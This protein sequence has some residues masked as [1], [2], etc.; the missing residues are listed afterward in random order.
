MPSFHLRPERAT[1]RSLCTQCFAYWHPGSPRFCN[2]CRKPWHRDRSR[3]RRRRGRGQLRQPRHGS[4]CDPHSIDRAP[5]H[6]ASWIFMMSAAFVMCSA[7][8]LKWSRPGHRPASSLPAPDM[9]AADC[10]SRPDSLPA[11][12]LAGTFADHA[13]CQVIPAR[14]GATAF[15]DRR[16]IP[17]PEGREF[18]EPGMKIFR[19]GR[20]SSRRGQRI[21]TTTPNSSFRLSVSFMSG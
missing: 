15:R 20:S 14:I 6:A 13:P 5:D 9:R 3:I 17:C 7:S 10:A 8:P 21:G 18:V 2:G 4:Q 11:G 16:Q 19:P 1:R 12:N